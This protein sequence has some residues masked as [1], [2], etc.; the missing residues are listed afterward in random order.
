MFIFKIL[1]NFDVYWPQIQVL[2]FRLLSPLQ[3]G[4][5]LACF[6][7]FSCII[8]DQ[9]FLEGHVIL[10]LWLV[11]QIKWKYQEFFCDKPQSPRRSIA[12]IFSIILWSSS[13]TSVISQGKQFVDSLYLIFLSPGHLFASWRQI[14]VKLLKQEYQIASLFQLQIIANVAAVSSSLHVDK[15]G[16]MVHTGAC[17][18][19]LIGQGG[20]R[21]YGLTCKWLQYFKNDRDR[22]DLVTCG[23]GAGVAAAFR[24][25]VGG[26]LFA[27]ESMSSW[28]NITWSQMLLLISQL[29]VWFSSTFYTRK[30]YGLVWTKWVLFIQYINEFH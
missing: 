15:A 3:F 18:A 16:P 17:I 19:A 11:T 25:P 27:L 29:Q 10:N 7:G 21:K 12:K 13:S 24:A 4:I 26:V 20:S 30:K 28:Y 14:P 5:I 2:F 22:R 1:S 6:G 9:L 23:S 8:W